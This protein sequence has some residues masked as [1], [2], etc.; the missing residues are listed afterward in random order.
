[1]NVA[2][3]CRNRSGDAWS[4]CSCRN[5]VGSILLGAVIAWFSCRTVEGL[6]EDHAVTA[7]PVYATPV[8]RPAAHHSAGLHY[9][10]PRQKECSGLR[11]LPS[12][13]TSALSSRWSCPQS[14]PRTRGPVVPSLHPNG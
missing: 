4:N 12:V 8:T 1:M 11:H 10:E 13:V 5:R 3:I 14:C 2:S 9:R 7:L 6:Q